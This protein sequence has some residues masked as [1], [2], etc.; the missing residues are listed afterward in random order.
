MAYLV[1]EC[2]VY[3]VNTV[4]HILFYHYDETRNVVVL[5]ELR[6]G[7]YN[8][9]E[10]LVLA[11]AEDHSKAVGMIHSSAVFNHV[12]FLADNVHHFLLGIDTLVG[13]YKSY[14]TIDGSIHISEQ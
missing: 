7:Q 11:I 10:S 12:K 14:K 13:F 2:G 5:L 8:I 9:A 4:F 3:Q 6:K 1:K